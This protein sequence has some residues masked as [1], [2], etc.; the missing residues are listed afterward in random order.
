MG[1][2]RLPFLLITAGVSV[3]KLEVPGCEQLGAE[4]YYERR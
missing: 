1:R 4:V 2:A 3:R